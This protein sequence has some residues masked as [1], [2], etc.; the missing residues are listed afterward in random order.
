MPKKGATSEVE[1]MHGDE[2]KPT[3]IDV[4][5][6]F[7]DGHWNDREAH[8]F[9]LCEPFVVEDGKPVNLKFTDV[10][11]W[12]LEIAKKKKLVKTNRET[13]E[14]DV[15][16]KGIR[17]VEQYYAGQGADPGDDGYL[18]A[19][20]PSQCAKRMKHG[21]DWVKARIKDGRL[22]YRK[23]TARSWRL[24]R[25]DAKKLGGKID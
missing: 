5:R 24:H 19:E 3:E 9:D 7:V 17:L 15:T 25:D 20:S 18:P 22:R 21:L 14:T 12:R 1:T 8:D 4:L 16:G 11:K 10:V 2:V 6:C 13:G 23:V